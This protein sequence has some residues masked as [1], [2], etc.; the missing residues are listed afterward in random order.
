MD[1]TWIEV[2]NLVFFKKVMSKAKFWQMIGRGTRLCPGLLDGED[3]QKFYIFDFCGNF[4]FFRMNKGKA[5]ANMIALQGAIFNL[6]FEISYKLQDIDYQI[7]RLIAYRKALV[8]QMSEKVQELPRDNFAVRQHL[9][10]VDLYATEANY[11]VL[12]YED[13]TSLDSRQ[14]YFVNQIVEYIVHNGMMKDLSVLQESPFT[15]QGGVV[16]IFTD[17]TVWMGIRRKK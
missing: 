2:L 1:M 3:K 4:E 11:Q 8:K 5:T 15:D 6:K 17:L 9:K 7:D 10:Y 16:E 12:T 14:I 13:S